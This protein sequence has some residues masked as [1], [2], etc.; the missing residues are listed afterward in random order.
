MSTID[1]GAC[2]VCHDPIG[3][4]SQATIELPPVNEL[5]D[6]E[7]AWKRY[8]AARDTEVFVNLATLLALPAPAHWRVVHGTCS[9]RAD[10]TAYA[11]LVDEVRTHADLLRWTVH[12][13][14]KTWFHSTDW[15]DLVRKAIA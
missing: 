14:D 4:D 9:D 11:L 7:D 8:H 3:A 5:A 15:D 6:I 2:E 13:H 1:W 10:T 12:L